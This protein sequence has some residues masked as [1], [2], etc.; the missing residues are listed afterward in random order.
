MTTTNPAAPATPLAPPDSS[1]IANTVANQLPFR[2]EFG[3]LTAL[4]GDASNRRYFRITLNGTPSS[5]ILMQLADPEGFKK[6]EEAVSG[7]SSQITE[8]PFT[9]V[10][11]HL[12]HTGVTVPRL[13]YYDRDGGLLYLDV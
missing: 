2:G 12:C 4:A 3:G 1:R 9:N 6:S 11:T 13:Q 7:A 8:L 5:L 10:L